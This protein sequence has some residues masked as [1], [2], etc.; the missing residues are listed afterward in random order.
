MNDVTDNSHG[1]YGARR[2]VPFYRVQDG[3]DQMTPETVPRKATTQVEK[4]SGAIPV[5]WPPV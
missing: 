1:G 2:V 3:I 4:D 5:G